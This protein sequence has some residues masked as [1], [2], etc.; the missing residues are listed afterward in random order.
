[1]PSC[2]CCAIDSHFDRQR[3]QKKLDSYRAQ[4]PDA[5][6]KLLLNALEAEG[7]AAMTLLDIGAGVGV[8]GHELLKAG[9]AKVCSV[10]ASAAAIAAARE[11]AERLGHAERASFLHGD[12]VALADEIAPADIVTLDRVI[13]CYPDMPALVERSAQRA[14]QF[15]GAVY[16]RDIWWLR[17][18]A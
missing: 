10:E 5:T 14:R 9:V 2:D 13:C 17:L 11:E 1:M 15:Y 18:A 8:L 12:F 3:V 7:G 16:P 6:T 4:G